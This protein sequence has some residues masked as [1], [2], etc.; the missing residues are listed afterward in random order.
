[1]SKAK[2]TVT[3][4]DET[5]PMSAQA[6]NTQLLLR[7]ADAA[8]ALAISESKLWSMTAGRQIPCVRIG[9]SVRY[10]PASLRAWIEQQKIEALA[11]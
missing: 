4:N 10:C 1:M 7:P 6:G 3:T 8:K 5:Q 9:K 11:C 2:K